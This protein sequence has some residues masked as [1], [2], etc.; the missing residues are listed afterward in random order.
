MLNLRCC[1]EQLES[2]T[3]KQE[4]EFFSKSTKRISKRGIQVS[5]YLSTKS[6]NL[7]NHRCRWLGRRLKSI[8]EINVKRSGM[9]R[10]WTN[11]AIKKRLAR[12]YCCIYCT[13]CFNL[14][15]DFQFPQ[16]QRSPSKILNQFSSFHLFFK[17]EIGQ[18]LCTSQMK[19]IWNALSKQNYTG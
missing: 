14:A 9:F 18:K 8:W 15:N 7:F 6:R 16:V 4:L 13:A 2:K 1:V 10:P 3:K 19:V 12:W 11:C 17:K 5:V